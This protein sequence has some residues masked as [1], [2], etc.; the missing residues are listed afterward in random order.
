MINPILIAVAVGLLVALLV[1]EKKRGTGLI[2]TFKVP[3]SCLF[4][5]TALMMVHAD[6]T[7][8]L[9]VL[10]GLLCGLAGDVC[11]A[12]KSN[13]AFR[14]GLIVFLI[15]HVL[16]VVAFAGLTRFADWWTL[17]NLLLLVV[18]CGIF[19]KL[20]PNLGPMLIPVAIYVVVISIMLCA[21]WVAFLNPDLDR[22]ASRLILI[23]AAAFYAS[24]IFVARDRFLT[25]QFANRLIGLP[26]YYVGQF[27][28]AF[29]TGYV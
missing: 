12:L 4:V 2:L 24:D 8:H 29:S 6:R 21:A 22:I 28:I 23:G 20:R 3:L 27:L 14:I 1:A 26:L 18:S 13:K 19:L 11:L 15:G 7:Y 10:A 25:T 17:G 9:L 5:L 16:Y